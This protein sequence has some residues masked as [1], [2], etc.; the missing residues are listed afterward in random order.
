MSIKIYK[1]PAVGLVYFEGSRLR[2]QPANQLSVSL[3][4]TLADRLVIKR[5]DQ[6]RADGVTPRTKFAR[7]LYTR[8]LD[9][10]GNSF[11]NRND[12]L[13]YLQ[14]TFVLSAVTTDAEYQGIW[15]ATGNTPDIFTDITG[16]VAG[17]FYRITEAG[18]HNSVDYNPGDVVIFNSVSSGWDRFADNSLKI[19]DIEGSAI[20]EFD[21]VVDAG[22]AGAI[23]TGSALQPYTDI[24][25]ALNAS[26]VNNTILLKG[27]L[28]KPNTTADLYTLPHSLNIYGTKDAITG[29]QSYDATNGNCWVF[30]GTDYTAEFLFEGF[31]IRNAGQYGI[32]LKKGKKSERRDLDIQYCGWDGDFSVFNPYLPT[33]VSGATF[34]YDSTDLTGFYPSVNASNGGAVRIEKFTTVLDVSNKITNNLRGCRLQGCGVNG[35]GFQTRNRIYGNIESG[36]YWALDT[37]LG[38]CQNM[39]AMS[40]YI[41][42]NANNGILQVGGLNNKVGANEVHSNWNAGFCCF[43][44]ANTTVRDAG[45]YNNNKSSKNGIGNTGDAKA[46]IQYNDAFSYL[47]TSFSVSADRRYLM[48]VNNLQ[49]HNT[50]LG[51]NT[52]RTGIYFD[53]ALNA[54]PASEKNIISIDNVEFNGQEVGIDMSVLNTTNLK[55]YKGDNA[56]INVTTSIKEPASG[57]YY[58]LPFSNHISY[59]STADFSV[60]NTGNITIKEG[61]NGAVVNPYF[62]NQLQAIAKGSEI[63]VILKGS[64]KIQFTAPV[65]GC[66]IDGVFVNSVLNQALIQLNNLFTNTVGFSSGGNPVTAF[67]LSNNDLTITLQDS[68]SF[69]VDVTTLGVDEDKFVSSGALNGSNLELTMNDATIITIDA[70]NM[71]NG[72]S[73]TSINDRWFISYGTNA[74]QE[75]GTSINDSTVN[76]QLPFYF[77]QT[78]SQGDV[79]KWNFQSNG[80][81]N[82]IMGIWDGAEVATAY[83]GGSVTPSNWGTMFIY[84]GGFI[85]GSNSTLTNTTNGTKYLVANGDP[86]EMRFD[87]LGFLTLIDVSVS[88]EVEIA[89]TTIALSVTEFNIQMHTWANGVLPNGIISQSGWTIV[90]D[91]DSDED[92]IINGIQDHTVIKSEFSVIPGEKI[93]FMLDEVGQGDF[94]GLNYTAAATGVATAEEQLEN[95]FIYQTNEAIVLD[96]AAGV[97]DWN[98][99][100]LATNYFFAAS[101]NQYRDGGA[102]TIQ[103]M[104]SIRYMTDNSIE[105][106]DEDSNEVVATA[107]Q[108]GNGSPISLYFGVRGNRAYYS[109]PVI[110]KQTI[111]QGSQPDVNF[112]PT[113]ANQT[114]SVNEGGVLNF[115]VVTSGNLVNQI[116]EVDAPSWMSMNQLTGI[117]SGTAPAFTGT[118]ADTIVVN[119]KAGN[120][121]GG[122]V[123]FT[124][125]VTVLEVAS[126][127]NTKSLKFPAASSAYL[128][129]QHINVTALQRTGN[130]SGAS[131]AWSISI[132]VKPSTATNTQT[133]FY[134]GGDDLA[135]EGRIELSQFSGGNIIF[136]YGSTNNNLNFIGVGNFPTGQWNHVLLTY[137]GGTTGSNS[138]DIS[139]YFG[140][141]SMFINGNNGVSQVQHNNYGFASG[142]PADKFRIGRLLGAT[143]SAYLLDGIVNQV[144]I[145]GTDESANVATIYNAGATQDLSTLSSAPVHYYEID[146][147][148]TTIADLAGNAD[149]TAFNFVSAD[150]VTDAP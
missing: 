39:T 101:L 59:L 50:G 24:Q 100:T 131:D 98:A 121:I 132:W 145:W 112:V 93:M 119:C 114:A 88:P 53:V 71:I 7:L 31:K 146:S 108:N 94:F 135:N 123:E 51:S 37:E 142:I 120:A 57:L 79:F 133:I 52:E 139:S 8:I 10:D 85:A 141:F 83:N 137:D 90:H 44:G 92:G 30:E 19:A 109:I 80:G 115:Q 136:R 65:S 69:T 5:L 122:T 105:I 106:F 66:S 34:G 129:G 35:N 113:V 91:F 54:L 56:Y 138:A 144:A 40:N 102:G 61:A 13:A 60:S 124:V 84:A 107:K 63:C 147:S 99:N 75:V 148:I 12:A 125:T 118:S 6:F 27:D 32:H 2:P 11:T 42:Y 117:L 110:S 89:K 64:K 87:E 38:G 15:T 74:N 76:Q 22:Y 149:F 41:A 33:T 20:N 28:R 150:L 127:T 43:A 17:D 72:S 4:P 29:F 140:R 128:N 14:A 78:F 62:V 26:S 104:F 36:L 95:T 9:V 47:A 103:G 116:V 126:Y 18:T 81:A 73:L 86:L 23:Q 25:T 96:T 45:F 55:I 143:T 70:S 77:G 67:T 134:Y 68:T 48:S 1:D 3:H 21:I 58:E 46:S 49:I 82:L 111:G 97:S 130:G 16:Y